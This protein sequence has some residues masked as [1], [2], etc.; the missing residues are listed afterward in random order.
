MSDKSLHSELTGLSIIELRNLLDNKKISCKELVS[1]YVDRI[2]KYDKSGPKLN[3]VR[4]LNP[5]VFEQAA[6]LD[7]ML[8]EGQSKGLLHGIPVLLKDCIDTKGAIHT[9]CGAVMMKDHYAECN[10]FIVDRLLN[11]GALILGKANMS[12]WYGFVSTKAPSGYSA[13]AGGS[14]LNPYKTGILKPGGSSGGC[15]VAVSAGLVTASIGTE[16]S[17]SIIEPAYFC[18]V[19]GFKPTTGLVSRSGILPV[20]TGQDSP[21]PITENV[22]DAAIITAFMAGYDKKDITTLSAFKIRNEALLENVDSG[23]LA[24]KRIGIA[25]DGYYD[26]LSEQ[27]KLTFDKAINVLIENGVEIIDNIPDFLPG[28]IKKHPERYDIHLSS[29]AMNHEFKVR[30]N[31]YLSNLGPGVPVHSLSQLIEWNKAHKSAIP[32]GQDYLEE[33]EAI[34]DPLMTEQYLEAKNND[35]YICGKMGVNGA[36]KNH[37]LDALIMPGVAGQGIAPRT[38]NPIITIPAGYTDSGVPVGLNF[39]G[40]FMGDAELL[41]L[42]RAC[43]KVMP[44]RKPPVL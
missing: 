20:M 30:F 17:G 10:A 41:K 35:L 19:V 15:A 31:Y 3:S 36:L 22:T 16:T 26:D 34:N 12:E 5:D 24:G 43:E 39:V 28:Q 42:A 8:K 32:Y 18:S 11:A 23:K 29:V 33:I 4:E 27:E 37:K 14:M 38:G 2:S 6:Y 7:D 44:K 40:H 1:A 13:I 21:G 25:R 9:T